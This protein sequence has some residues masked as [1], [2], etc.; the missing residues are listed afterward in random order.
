MTET[1]PVSTQTA[2]DD[3]LDKRIASVGRVHPHLEV[4]IVDPA[5]GTV[6]PRGTP[7]EQCT[8]GYSVML[9]YWGHD[10]ATSRAIDV[11]GWM[12]SCDLAVME[13]DGYASGRTAAWR[14][15]TRGWRGDAAAPAAGRTSRPCA[16][17][18]RV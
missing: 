9:G 2:V 10:E 11:A 17:A 6:V 8:R 16:S 12:H 4:K 18:R 5:S 15:Q 7:G 3:P 13:P 14:E 1:S